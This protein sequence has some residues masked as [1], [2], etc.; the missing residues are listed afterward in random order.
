VLAERVIDT[1]ASEGMPAARQ[2]FRFEG[3]AAL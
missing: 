3:L 1:D 2:V